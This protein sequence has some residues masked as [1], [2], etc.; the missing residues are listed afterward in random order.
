MWAYAGSVSS[1][2]RAVCLWIRGVHEPLS[3]PVDLQMGC[4]RTDGGGSARRVQG[5]DPVDAR[6]E[7]YACGPLV[8]VWIGGRYYSPVENLLSLPCRL[9]KKKKE[10]GTPFLASDSTPSPSLVLDFYL[11]CFLYT[12]HVHVFLCFHRRKVWS[13]RAAVCM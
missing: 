2:T 11:S 12:S 8:C 13:S 9:R 3:V 10:D 7:T 5:R 6:G 4:R 1:A